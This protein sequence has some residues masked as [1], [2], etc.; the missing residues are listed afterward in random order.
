MFLT[1]FVKASAWQSVGLL[2]ARLII[3]VV[4]AMA[5]TFKVMSIGGTATEISNAGFPFA[6]PLAYIAAVFELLI[7]LSFLTGAYFKE[8]AFLA[9]LYV[10]FLAMA[11]HGPNHWASNMD[12]FGF[13][14]DH[15]TFAAGLIALIASG[16]G[17]FRI[18]LGK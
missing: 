4:F 3:A 9:A 6:L 10:L 11:F 13:F 1:T 2:V 15:F 18:S 12:E 16:P 14:I 8:F 5:L 17:R 7:V